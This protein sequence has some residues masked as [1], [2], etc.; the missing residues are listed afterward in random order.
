[1]NG[2]ERRQSARVDLAILLT[3]QTLEIPK[4]AARMGLTENISATGLYL[5]SDSSSEMGTRLEISLRMPE[6]VTGKPACE[7]CC[8]GRVL[9]VQARDEYHA[10]PGAAVVFHDYEVGAGERAR[11]KN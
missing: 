1:M 8:R 3:I 7:W 4:S 9:R 5:A 11:F 2:R 6:S 10:R